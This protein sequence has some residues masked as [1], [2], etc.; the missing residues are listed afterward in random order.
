MNALASIGL[1]LI[2]SGFLALVW[3]ILQKL[4]AGRVADAP[5]VKT[6][7][8]AQ[9]GTAVAGNRGAVSVEGNVACAQPLVSPVTGQQCLYYDVKVVAHW[10][11]GE[12]HK[13]RE[14]LHERRA[15]AF[16]IDDGSGAVA[17]DASKGG[18]F[19]PSRTKTEERGTGLIG[20]MAGTEL[21]FG[22]L[23]VSTGM[24]NHIGTKYRV[25]ESVVPVVSKLYVCGKASEGGGAVRSPEWRQLIM[26]DKSRDE[27][28]GAATKGA[29]IF[30]PV[31]AS[32]T[33]VGVVLGVV[34]RLIAQ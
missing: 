15:A 7:D 25:A 21:V 14:V 3:G 28:L 33:A 2:V 27:L 23:R 12:A 1:I 13:S 17:V 34:S 11:E 10:K 16:T 6:G 18:D 9:K 20:A 31:G 22:N 30:L 29:K 19:E 26:S 8:A 4:K 5:L 24:L 32:V